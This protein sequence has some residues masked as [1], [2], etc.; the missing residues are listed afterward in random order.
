MRLNPFHHLISQRFQ[1]SGGARMRGARVSEHHIELVQDHGARLHRAESVRG[2]RSQLRVAAR[3]SSRAH[4]GARHEVSLMII[5]I[6]TCFSLPHFEFHTL[7]IIYHTYYFL[8]NFSTFIYRHFVPC[9]NNWPTLVRNS[10]RM[11]L[12]VLTAVVAGWTPYFGT[13]LG[14]VGGLTDA[15]QAFVLPPLIYLSMHSDS[16][17]GFQRLMYRLILIWGIGTISYTIVSLLNM[18]L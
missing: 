9:A 2:D 15:L 16:L 8:L 6:S 11:L 4:R 12:V 3:A 18:L 1:R 13:L 7:F 17:S 5:Y 14:Q 10:V